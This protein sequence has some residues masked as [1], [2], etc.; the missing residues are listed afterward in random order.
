MLKLYKLT[1]NGHW[2]FYAVAKNTDEAETMLKDMF[3]KVNKN[4]Y[5]YGFENQRELKSIEVVAKWYSSPHTGPDVIPQLL[6]NNMEE[7]C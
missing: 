4:G 1:T 5:S 6:V 2:V 3:N 7:Q